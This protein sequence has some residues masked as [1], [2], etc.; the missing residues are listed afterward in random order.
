[1]RVPSWRSRPG[2]SVL[3][4]PLSAARLKARKAV[5]RWPLVMLTGLLVTMHPSLNPAP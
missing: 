3:A 5:A 2:E 1:M 4:A